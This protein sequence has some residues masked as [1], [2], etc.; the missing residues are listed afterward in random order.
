MLKEE[1]DLPEIRLLVVDDNK[2]SNHS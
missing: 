1:S 2:Q